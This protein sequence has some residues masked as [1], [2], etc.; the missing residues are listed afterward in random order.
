MN[1]DKIEYIEQDFQYFFPRLLVTQCNFLMDN[2]SKDEMRTY[3]L[4]KESGVSYVCH[5]ERTNEIR[6]SENDIV[7]NGI[8]DDYSVSKKARVRVE[9]TIASLDVLLDIIYHK[10]QIAIPS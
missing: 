6:Y 5:N 8:G 7:N 1:L 2:K 10:M 4:E 3:Y 9:A